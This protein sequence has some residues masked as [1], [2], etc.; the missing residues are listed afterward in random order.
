[1]YRPTGTRSRQTREV[2]AENNLGTFVRVGAAFTPGGASL[3]VGI[4]ASTVVL[5]VHS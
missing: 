4:L 2:R 1:M 5:A 3:L